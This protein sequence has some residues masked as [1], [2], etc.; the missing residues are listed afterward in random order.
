MATHGLCARPLLWSKPLEVP[1][2]SL[3][4]IHMY[5]GYRQTV[6]PQAT[7]VAIMMIVHLLDMMTV[8]HYW[9]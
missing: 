6:P 5:M 3:R 7:P 4:V 8:H 2:E 9:T 1:A